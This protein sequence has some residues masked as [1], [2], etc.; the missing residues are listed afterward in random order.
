MPRRQESEHAVDL[1]VSSVVGHLI[2]SLQHRRE[3]APA[4]TTGPEPRSET[5]LTLTVAARLRTLV[6]ER[7]RG[8]PAVIRM[9]AAATDDLATNWRTV[10]R[11]E[12]SLEEQ[13]DEDT[14]FA[15]ELRQVVER[16]EARS[17][18]AAGYL[19]L[20]SRSVCTVAGEHTKSA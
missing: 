9:L 2:A 17:S 6:L 1:L 10:R 19:A 16:I 7:L 8:D 20:D 11:V 5:A 14:N 18:S 4:S 15:E 3:A 12:L 13:V